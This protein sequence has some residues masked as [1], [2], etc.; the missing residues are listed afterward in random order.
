M[1]L[2]EILKL[3]DDEIDALYSKYNN[4]GK[5]FA[6]ETDEYKFEYKT[7]S[8]IKVCVNE[9]D[10]DVFLVGGDYRGSNEWA[11]TLN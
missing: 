4:E 11:V 7:S 8:G 5:G 10:D 3:T 9:Y 2:S 1:K 6:P